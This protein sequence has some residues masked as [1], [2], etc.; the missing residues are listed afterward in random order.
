MNSSGKYISVSS[1]T[2]IRIEMDHNTN[3]T[4]VISGTSRTSTEKRKPINSN[5]FKDALLA[6]LYSQVELLRDQLKEKDFLI[7]TL[8][9]TDGEM[10]TYDHA[11]SKY[12]QRKKNKPK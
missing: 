6:S 12:A 9:I 11:T 1:D 7:R 8:I 5:D 10:E 4:N 2:E 3:D